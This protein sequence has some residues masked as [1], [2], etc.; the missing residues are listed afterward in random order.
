[1]SYLTKKECTPIRAVNREFKGWVSKMPSQI[2]PSFR[3]AVGTMGLD[4]PIPAYMHDQKITLEGHTSHVNS[5]N[6]LPDG[7]LVSGSWDK[8]L[9]VWTENAEG[10]WSSS[11]PLKSNETL[12]VAG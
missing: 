5:V 1:M 9:R 10:V 6:V 11:E 3:S 2:R 12:S 4:R 8:T 7:R